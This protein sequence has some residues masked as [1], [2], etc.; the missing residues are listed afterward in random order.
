MAVDHGELAKKFRDAFL[1]D[2]RVFHAPGRVNLI[3]E[4]TDYNE[5]FVLPI[6]IDRGTSVAA[7][8]RADRIVRAH[9]LNFG[10]IREFDLDAPGEPRRGLW[11]D[12][13]EG[14]ARALESRG[15][16]LGGANLLVE[17]DLPVGAGLSS[18]AALE[19][20]TGLALW[21][22]SGGDV[23]RR[24]LALAGQQAE[25]EYVGAMVGVMDQLVSVFGRFGHALMI[26]CRSLETRAIPIKLD[27]TTLVVFD[28]RVKHE[29][30]TSAY[31]TRREECLAGVGV[32]CE[33]VAGCSA[34]RDADPISLESAR[35]RLN[36]TV[37]RRCRHVVTEN[38]RTSAAA[39]ALEIGDAAGFGRLMLE[40]HASLRDD[41]DVSCDELDTLVDLAVDAGALGA[42]MTG[43]GFGGC[44]VCLAPAAR[45]EEMA[46]AVA[47]GYRARFGLDP[48]PYPVVPSD[49]AGEVAARA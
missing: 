24:T 25:H 30:A 36:P 29:L 45:L 34:L 15:V 18:S 5:G 19:I 6:A 41:F 10:D 3:G 26:D 33:S 49:G 39:R 11:I 38:A 22:L 12:Y 40:S 42:R 31:N 7:A 27:G 2:P 8:P 23:N 32:I 4:H 44:V 37:F 14:V 20:A 46:E 43:G 28:S 21:S 9:S 35:S 13:V 47:R 17:S 1:D 16:R 48:L